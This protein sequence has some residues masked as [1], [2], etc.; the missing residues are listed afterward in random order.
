M[1]FM[2]FN[3]EDHIGEKF[4][5]CHLCGGDW[6]ETDEDTEQ[7][8][9]YGRLYPESLMAERDGFWYC[10]SHYTWRFQHKDEDDEPWDEPDHDREL[11]EKGI[12]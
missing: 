7:T 6:F 1:K 2:R 4:R 5:A 10:L 8:N 12:V 11:P 3:P 9:Y